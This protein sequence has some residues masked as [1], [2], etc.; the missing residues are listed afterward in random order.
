MNITGFKASPRWFQV[1]KRVKK[2]SK[3]KIVGSGGLADEEV[4][5]QWLVKI[6]FGVKLQYSPDDTYNYD[7][8]C[9]YWK[10]LPKSTYDQMGKYRIFKLILCNFTEHFL[11][12]LGRQ[13]NYDEA[14]KK[15]FTIGCCANM[16]GKDKRP[17]HVI[18]TAA[19]PRCFRGIA[20]N[21]DNFPFDYCSSKKGWMT[22]RLWHEYLRSW[23]EELKLQG[24][25]IC[26]IVDN[27]SAHPKDCI[28]KYEMIE[29]IFLPPNV[30]SLIQPMDAGIISVLKHLF[31]TGL[32]ARLLDEMEKTPANEP[33]TSDF[34]LY[35]AA[36]MCGELWNGLSA[37]TIEKCF[38]KAKWYNEYIDEELVIDEAAAVA[39]DEITVNPA[40][41]N[42]DVE[43]LG[44]L[45][46]DELEDEVIVNETLQIEVMRIADFK[47]MLEADPTAKLDFYGQTQPFIDVD[48]IPELDSSSDYYS[49]NSMDTLAYD[50]ESI[51]M[52]EIY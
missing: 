52:N 44:D 33:L 43:L 31:R 1:F 41:V 3:R 38:A 4:A 8:S 36:K 46:F 16:S 17:L 40:F 32:V 26:L 48:F 9:C 28:G 29:I 10:A 39:G 24:R 49:E 13:C 19:M 50:D 21:S 11:T 14:C 12:F 45:A 34:N 47:D 7:E 20:K 25:K 35:D 37:E 15:R 2:I 42:I 27:C 23:N 18:G 30:T 51:D 6:L 22:S 5:R